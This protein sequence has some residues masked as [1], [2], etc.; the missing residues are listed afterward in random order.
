MSTRITKTH[1]IIPQTPSAGDTWRGV[2]H[3]CLAAYEE[4]RTSYEESFGADS[5][6]VVPVLVWI[7]RLQLALD[8]PLSAEWTFERALTVL[9]RSVPDHP[10]IAEI[11]LVLEQV[12]QH[13][14]TATCANPCRRWDICE[15]ENPNAGGGSDDSEVFAVDDAA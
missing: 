1:A 5:P 13:Y 11:E 2:I 14:G 4:L 6:R 10:R 12:R 8:C 15:H 3:S 7:G 9:S